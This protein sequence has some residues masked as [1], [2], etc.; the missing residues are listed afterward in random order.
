MSGNLSLE[1]R[2]VIQTMSSNGHSVPEISNYIHRN[3]TTVY[4]E[5]S[6]AKGIDGAYDAHYAHKLASSNMIRAR[7]RAVSAEA[8]KFIE[9]K[10]L[11]VQWSPE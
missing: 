3:K 2:I 8:I 1:E 9:N 10:I 4:R 11:T 6:K 7:S 5:V